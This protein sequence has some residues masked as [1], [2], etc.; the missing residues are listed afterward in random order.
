MRRALWLLALENWICYPGERVDRDR[1][2]PTVQQSEEPWTAFQGTRDLQQLFLAL[3]FA[4]YLE[5]DLSWRIS[6]PGEQES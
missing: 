5:L 4:A 6:H 3:F 2:H 1:A